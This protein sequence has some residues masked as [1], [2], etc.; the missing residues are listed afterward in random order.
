[1]CNSRNNT[2]KRSLEVFLPGAV[3]ITNLIDPEIGYE[4]RATICRLLNKLYVD[5]EPR[6]SKI[7]P[8]LCKVLNKGGAANGGKQ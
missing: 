1:M 8:E 6:R 4:M 3:L 5:Q 2:W 7:Y